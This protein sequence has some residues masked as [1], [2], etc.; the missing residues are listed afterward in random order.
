MRDAGNPT[1]IRNVC[2]PNTC[3]GNHRYTILLGPRSNCAPPRYYAGVP[4]S[5]VL[6]TLTGFVVV[7]DFE[8]RSWDSSVGI[9][10]GYGQDGSGLIPGTA[11]FFSPQHPDRLWGPLTLLPNAYLGLLPRW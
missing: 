3:L 9:A 2:L 7:F 11:R 8:Y 6:I 1:E 5:W 4:T 10:T